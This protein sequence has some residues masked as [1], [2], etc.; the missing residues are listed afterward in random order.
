MK[1]T[2]WQKAKEIFDEA[3]GIAPE[4]RARFVET[5]CSGDEP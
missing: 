2:R 3:L 4:L 5:S 1:D